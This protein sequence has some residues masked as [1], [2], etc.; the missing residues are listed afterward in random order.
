VRHT[1][2]INLHVR[3]SED[4]LF[5]SIL[6]SSDRYLIDPIV[7]KFLIEHAESLNPK[8]EIALVIKIEEQ[9]PSGEGKIVDAIHRHF[10]YSQLRAE[11][12]VR[13]ILKL[14]SKSLFVSFILLLLTV[15]VA[16]TIT[17]LF[18]ENS[19]M[20]TLRELLIILAWVA[21]WRPVDLLLY[22]WRG[23]KR[24]GKLLRKLADCKVS[25]QKTT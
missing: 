10:S 19:I 18:P 2:V 7:E 4:I 6:L 13:E 16:I 20:I 17:T 24:K 8:G 5:N 21:L 1:S 11:T 9:D 22:E 23:I 14:G 25:F 15:V 12:S 3:R